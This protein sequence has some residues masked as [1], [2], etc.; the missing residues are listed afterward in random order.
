MLSYS[1]PVAV[2]GSER[3]EFLASAVEIAGAAGRE[4]LPYFRGA[5]EIENKLTD[6][7]FDPVTEADRAAEAVIREQLRSRY[8]EH[9]ILGE[10]FGHEPGNGLTWVID[11]IDGTRAF[12]SGMVHWGVLLGLFDGENPIVG[13]LH[14]PFTD[15]FFFGDGSSA[16]YRRGSEERS[17]TV[18]RC[19]SVEEAVV[20][21]TSPRFIGNERERAGFG[22][23]EQ[24]VRMT[25]YGGDCYL[26][27][28][29][30]MG[31]V[32]IGIDGSLQPYDI[33]ALIPIIRGA[34]GIVTC[35]DGS[36]P[37]MGGTVIASASQELHRAALEIL[38]A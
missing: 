3:A 6:G 37:A 5:V 9:G 22:D 34:G 28:M 20:A 15:E 8:P 27:G 13:V 24:A 16:G 11:P 7:R 38:T 21:T 29:V 32:D 33:Q 18:S 2:S 26:F 30:A 10:E 17:L 35:W 14:Q 31:F 25:R 36:N 4:T 1:A 23:L 19:R 12:M